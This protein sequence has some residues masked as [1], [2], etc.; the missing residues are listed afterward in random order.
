MN[1]PLMISLTLCFV[2][3][4]VGH[5]GIKMAESRRDVLVNRALM[6]VGLVGML[7]ALTV[8]FLLTNFNH[9]KL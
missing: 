3:A 8:Y 5:M 1:W 7:A 6:A 2:V 4:D 9:I